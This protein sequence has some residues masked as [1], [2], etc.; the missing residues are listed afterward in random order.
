MEQLLNILPWIWGTIVVA[1]IVIE[2]FLNDIDAIWFSI[3]ALMTLVVSL[4]K[5]HICIQLSVFVAI[6]SILLFTVGR[7]AKRLLMI[8]NILKVRQP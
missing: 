7:R 1:T 3:G 2:L 8:K 6:T 5:V 4:F